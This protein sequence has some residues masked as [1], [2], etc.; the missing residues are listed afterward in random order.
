MDE[1]R[2]IGQALFA[3]I[4]FIIILAVVGFIIWR[5]VI[6]H[7]ARIAGQFCNIDDDCAAGHYCGGGNQ[8][9]QG[10]SGGTEGAICTRNADCEVGLR[11]KGDETVLR[12]TRKTF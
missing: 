2:T 9:V 10:V 11:C 8:C 1:D 7:E 12:C 6:E 4:I 3:L 5:F